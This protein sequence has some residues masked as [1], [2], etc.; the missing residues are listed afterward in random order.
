MCDEIIGIY[1]MIGTH[2]VIRFNEHRHR[3]GMGKKCAKQAG[4]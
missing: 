4:Y 3:S 2:R 1:D